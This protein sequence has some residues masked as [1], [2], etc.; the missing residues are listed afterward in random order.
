MNIALFDFDGTI[1]NK[2]TFMLF[3]ISLVGRLK[4]LYGIALLSPI[5][6]LYKLGILSNQYMKSSII[7]FFYKDVSINTIKSR[8]QLFNRDVV[9]NIIRKKALERI[10]WHKKNND[11]IV[12]VSASSDLWLQEW[13]KEN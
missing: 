7:K 1:S 12:V 9:K 5:L 2:D 4:Y 13:C 3:T 8:A 11:I 10:D 6:L